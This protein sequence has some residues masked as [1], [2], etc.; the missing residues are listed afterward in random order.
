MKKYVFKPYRESFPHL[1][2]KEKKRI[3]SHVKN[4]LTLE[5]IGSTAVP[6][7]GGKGIIDIGI[8][9]RKEEMEAVSD[10]LQQLGYEFRPSHSTSDRYFLRADLPDEEEGIRRYHV[11]LMHPTWREW[12][13]MLF[14]R[15]YLRSHPDEVEIYAEIKRKAADAANEDGAKY[16]QQKDPLFKKVLKKMPIE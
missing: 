12:K 14:F 4:N 16:R 10:Q 11:H 2:E 5:H 13:E 6:H 1:F 9:V 8:A 3:A 7:L 15:D